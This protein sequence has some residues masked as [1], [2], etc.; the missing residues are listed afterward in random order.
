MLRGRLLALILACLFLCGCSGGKQ[1]KYRL[2]VI[3]KGMTHEFWQSI[4]RGADRAASDLDGEGIATE[5]I[6]DGPR[7]ESDASE[8]ISLIDQKLGMG[9]QGLVLA[10]QHSKQM[11]A[12]VERARQRGIPVVIIDSNLDRETLKNNPDLIVKYVATDNYNGG[13][14][15]AEHLLKLLRQDGIKAP[16][17]VLFRYQTGSESTEQREQGFIDVVEAEIKRQKDAGEPTITWLER[18]NAFAG[19]T[20]DSAQA[21]AGP[22]L[23]RLRGKG[24]DGIF[25][26]NESATTGFIQALRS[27]PLE[28]KPRLMG[29]D[30]SEP[31][32][33]AIRAGEVDGTIIQD[34]YRMGYLGV[35]TLVRHLEGDQVSATGKEMSTGEYLLTKDNIDAV[36][37]RE[38]FEPELQKKRTIARP[39]FPRR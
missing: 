17:L 31:L 12:P 3:P 16:K 37:T 33:Q 15:A 7:K 23:E 5:I 8:Q 28:K 9:I 11:V 39:N 26:V 35:W 10:P 30:S 32:L 29:F 36:E 38:K 24:V 19:S 20:V 25:A 21:A 34:P 6:W 4:H 13:K 27:Q 14:M 1:Y 22:L 18:D 2:A